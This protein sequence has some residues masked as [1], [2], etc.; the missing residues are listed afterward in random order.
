MDKIVCIIDGQRSCY[1]TCKHR[2]EG[3]PCTRIPPPHRPA[4]HVQTK[5]RRRTIKVWITLY[6]VNFYA[7]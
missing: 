1:M 2:T 3:L 7:N 6:I 4:V 5:V